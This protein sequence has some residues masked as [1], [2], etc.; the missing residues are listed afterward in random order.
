MAAAVYEKFY[1]LNGRPFQLNPDPRF[2][3]RSTGHKRAQAYMRYGLQQEEGFIVVTGDVGTG[4]TTL[5]SNLFAE[6]DEICRPA[7]TPRAN[8]ATAAR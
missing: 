7:C 3:F 4:K 5:V 8:P 2:F 1:K 6:L